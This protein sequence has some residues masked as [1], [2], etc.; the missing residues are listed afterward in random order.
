MA[1]KQLPDFLTAENDL[2][3]NELVY[4]AQS[5]KTRKSTL[6]K[7]KE[8]IIGTATLLTTDKTP[9]GAINELKEG[10]D[11]NTKSILDNSTQLNEKVNKSQV[12]ESLN[13]TEDGYV[14]GGKQGKILLDRINNINMFKAFPTFTNG[15]ADF[16]LD[17]VSSDS[18]VI[19]QAVHGNGYF[20]HK[21]ECSENNIHVELN[22]TEV[23]GIVSINIMVKYN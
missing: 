1:N 11:N 3:G 2:D 4:I 12:V 22:N 23:N 19:A 20:I 13:I 18:I 8:F 6:Q 16:N 14:L 10:I 21:V 5:G 9:I 15:V 7:I 17:G